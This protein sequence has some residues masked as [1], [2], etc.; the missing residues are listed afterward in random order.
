[1]R[2]Y[3]TLLGVKEQNGE[4]AAG[5]WPGPGRMPLRNLAEWVVLGQDHEHAA[6][7][8]HTARV[9]RRSEHLPFSW[10]DDTRP[11]ARECAMGA[12]EHHADAP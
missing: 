3:E 9:Q 7:P 5:L 11:W 6:I 2:P 8:A 12:P 10:Q 4:H 1:M